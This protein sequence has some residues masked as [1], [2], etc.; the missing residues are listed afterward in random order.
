ML[1]NNLIFIRVIDDFIG[2][3][4]TGGV[5]TFQFRN[6]ELNNKVKLIYREE[7]E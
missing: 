5:M 4:D 3:L 1:K 7:T 2:F 6:P